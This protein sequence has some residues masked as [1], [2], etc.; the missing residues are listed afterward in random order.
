M[1]NKPKTL[2]KNL[3]VAKKSIMGGKKRMKCK[4]CGY[5]EYELNSADRVFLIRIYKRYVKEK[6]IDS[7]FTKFS[8][9]TLE[10]PFS[11]SREEFDE[12]IETVE[13]D[14]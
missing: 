12:M 11:I 13:V 4:N 9:D 6:D 3:E 8:R 7:T 1:K 2:F 5:E 10:L 14:E